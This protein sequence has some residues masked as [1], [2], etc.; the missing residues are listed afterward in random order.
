[1]EGLMEKDT[2][3]LIA[4]EN[5]DVRLRC[6]E[7]LISKGA[8]VD[9]A[10]NGDE[11]QRMISRQSYDIVIADLWLPAVDGISLLK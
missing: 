5:S 1:M 9:E 4:D 10:K 11:A 2:R 6:R 8:V 7:M 3:I